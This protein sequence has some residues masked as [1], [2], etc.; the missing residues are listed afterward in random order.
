ME[1]GE[2]PCSEPDIDQAESD[3]VK[4]VQPWPRRWSRA[5]HKRRNETTVE[6]LSRARDES[7]SQAERQQCID[8]AVELNLPIAEALARRYRSRGE[9]LDDLIQVARLGLI[10]AVHRFSPDIGNF[11]AFA[12]PTIT[13]EIKRHFR[14]HFW[15]TPRPPRRLQNLHRE[16][17]HAWSAVAQETGG[18]RPPQRSPAG[19]AQIPTR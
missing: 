1:A 9:D 17:V 7:V 10:Q 15:S 2:F 4:P 13:G 14:D 11:A 18:S 8:L 12:V 6:L 16:A 3:T 19:S 5:H